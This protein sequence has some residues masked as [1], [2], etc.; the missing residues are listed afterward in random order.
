MEN[1]IIVN[2]FLKSWF[3]L[4]QNYLQYHRYMKIFENCYQNL[5]SPYGFIRDR[6]KIYFFRMDTIL[7]KFKKKINLYDNSFKTSI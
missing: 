3:A 1:D 4:V 5:S 6:M 7:K 2:Y